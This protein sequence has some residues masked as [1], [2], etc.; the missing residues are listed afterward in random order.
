[1]FAEQY[2]KAWTNTLTNEFVF[3]FM[4]LFLFFFFFSCLTFFFFFFSF[5]AFFLLLFLLFLSKE[6]KSLLLNWHEIKGIL[7]VTYYD[8]EYFLVTREKC[9]NG[10]MLNVNSTTLLLFN[11]FF[12]FSF[13]LFSSLR[14]SQIDLSIFNPTPRTSERAAG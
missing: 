9:S 7:F 10:K 3:C 5:L 13:C 8:S 4:L 12:F 6:L 2:A 14:R 1:M 11:C